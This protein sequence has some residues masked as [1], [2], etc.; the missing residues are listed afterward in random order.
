MAKRKRKERK[1][2]W[3]KIQPLQPHRTEDGYDFCPPFRE[4]DFFV[5]EVDQICKDH[6]YYI[7]VVSFL[8][9]TQ[10][11]LQNRENPNENY[12]VR[13]RGYR[14]SVTQVNEE[15]F[16]SGELLIFKEVE[17]VSDG[18]DTLQIGKGVR[19]TQ[20]TALIAEGLWEQGLRTLTDILLVIEAN[21][22][23]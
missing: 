17:T 13:T 18:D 14:W 10:F 15:S 9:P 5:G 2:N 1:E 23:K 3:S 7:N 20:P 4:V 19:G 22:L 11:F 12:Y 6:G 21:R 16:S 8:S